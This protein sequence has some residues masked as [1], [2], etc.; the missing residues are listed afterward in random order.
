MLPLKD[1]YNIYLKHPNVVID[2]RKV[3]D[4]C[5]F[6]ALQGASFDGN[7]FAEQAI[8]QGAAF[9]IIDNPE[10]EKNDRC[11][12]VDDVLKTLQD[13]AHF[14]RQ[15]FEIPVLAITGSNG[16][17]TTKELVS[18]VLN[19]YYISHCTQGNFNNHIGLPLTLLAMPKN[20]EIAVIE[21]GANHIGEIDFLCNITRPTHGLITNVGKAHLE[22]FGSFDGVKKA[23]GELYQFLAKNEGVAFINL[24]E[25]FLSDMSANIS[26]RIDYQQ[27]DFPSS[28]NIFFQTKL[29][30]EDPFVKVEF[31]DDDQLL[32]VQSKIIGNYNF[33][34][35]QTAI[36][37]GR[38][39]NVPAS[40]IKEAIEFY[41]PT[42]NRSQIIKN[43]SNTFILD[44]YNANPNS[45]RE[46]LNNLA[47][48][49]GTHK[50]A[51][52]GDMLELG[53]Y[54]QNEH[55]SL[56]EHAKKLNFD[57]LILVGKEFD[58]VKNNSP[59]HLHFP[60][61]EALKNWYSKQIFQNTTFLI[62]GSRGLKLE[63]LLD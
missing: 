7:Q 50:I 60:K 36:T 63:Q 24:D 45:M 17:T 35:I 27:N 40:K 41:I 56:L 20:T 39:F 30:D 8:Q 5:I 10:F 37:V 44:A 28:T 19:S 22:G 29:V 9:S 49:E 38:Y 58:K 3:V 55:E 62:K 18:A 51:I 43:G 26:H 42:N 4:G 31:M 23:K 33:N 1:L 11:I 48:V 52:L 61:I 54:S 25:P 15:T 34:N 2:S 13:L 47:K 6:F 21:M 16:K 59:S 53:D 14:H 46:A 32:E 57:Q 12:L